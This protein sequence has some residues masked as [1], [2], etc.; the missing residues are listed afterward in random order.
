MH[1]TNRN[2]ADVVKGAL[3]LLDEI[4]ALYPDQITW[5]SNTPGTFF[6]DKLL[7]TDD[8]RCGRYDAASLIAAHADARARFMEERK[9]F[10]LYD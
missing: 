2:T 10:L 6:I 1:I 9:P 5:V 3:S 7:G 4:R 8:Y